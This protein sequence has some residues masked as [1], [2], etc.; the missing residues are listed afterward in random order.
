MQ[1]F[2]DENFL[3]TT[4]FARTLYHAHAASM[5]IVDYHCHINPQEIYENRR[6]DNITQVWLGGDHYKWRVMRAC[7]VDE[8][9]ITG[10]ASDW[11]KFFAWASS[12]PR[13]VGNPLYHWTHL[14][15]KRY[16]GYNGVLNEHTAQEVWDLCNKKL[17]CEE[18]RVRG[19][20]DSSNVRLICT[21]DDPIDSLIWHERI[22]ADETCRVRVLP[23]WRPDKAINIQKSEFVSYIKKLEEAANVKIDSFAALKEALC[24]RL[25]YFAAHGCCASDH[26]IDAIVFAPASEQEVDAIFRRAMAGETVEEAD[27][28][29]YQS[30]M[31]VFLGREYAKRSWVMQLHYGALRNANTRMFERLG[32][33]TGYDC[34]NTPDTARALVAL[35]DELEKTNELPRTI[36]Y[37]L[38]PED[39]AMLTTAMGCFQHA[40]V[41]NYVQHGS[42]WWFNDTRR[43]MRRQL[44]NLADSSVL[45]NF[46]GMLTDSRSFLSYTRHEYFRR[47][48][49]QLLG[50]WVEAGEYPADEAFLG[51]LVEDVSYNNAT[52]FFGFDKLLNR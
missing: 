24:K 37:S 49:C 10:N 27:V 25:D 41:R 38:N 18:L 40:G 50:E 13:A 1:N 26:G 14:E 43:G 35:L 46:V 32:P 9:C 47:V 19:I 45:G 12:L 2:M 29:R 30:A 52:A 36:L 8:E 17:A 5:P 44:E 16:F 39:N 20:I 6:F 22:A 15:L 23:A 42:A 28:L 3:L 7:G 51:K 11:E 34:I 4:D 31:L 33:D 48:L 21:T